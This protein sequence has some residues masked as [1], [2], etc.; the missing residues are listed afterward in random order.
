MV[1]SEH[2]AATKAF[3]LPVSYENNFR[4]AGK[5]DPNWV[6]ML[7]AVRTGS[8]MVA[9]VFAEKDGVL[10][11]ENRY[12]LPMDKSLKLAVLSANHDSKVA[13]H[14]GQFKTLEQI[15]RNFFWLKI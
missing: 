1:N 2:I 8:K 13:G 12:V 10:L 7:E 14:F 11:F 4:A 6:A 3:S 15:W 5:S 9:P